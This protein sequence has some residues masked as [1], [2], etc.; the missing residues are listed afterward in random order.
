LPAAAF[1]VRGSCNVDEAIL[2]LK[3]SSRTEHPER[4]T[5]FDFGILVQNFGEIGEE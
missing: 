3:C 4:V 2:H 5:L 1:P